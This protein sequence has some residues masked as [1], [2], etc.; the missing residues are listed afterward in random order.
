MQ[1]VH[2]KTS[3]DN[4]D[5]DRLDGPVFEAF[6]EYATRIKRHGAVALLELCNSGGA[7]EEYTQQRMDA[8]CDTFRRGAVFARRAGF[9]GVLIHGGHGFLLQQ[10]I[11]PLTNRRNDDYG[12]SM[13]NRARFPI[14]ILKALRDG[15]GEDGILEMRF[16]AQDGVEGGM[17]IEDSCAFFR[18]I[19]GIPDI[20]HVSNGLKN[21][22][23]R[24][25][26]FTDMYDA[27]GHNIQYA[28][29][30]KAVV[31]KSK[32]AVIGGI[33][34]PQMCEDA[35]AAGKT[36]FVI[37]SRQAI[38][39]P[40]FPNKAREGRADQ[41]RR[42]I[43]CF[44]CYPGPSEHETEA[45]WPPPGGLPAP[46]GPPPFGQFSFF[47]CPN[48]LESMLDAI[49]SDGLDIGECTINPTANLR[50]YPELFPEV[51]ESRSVLVIGGSLGGMEAAITAAERGHRV[52]LV[53]SRDR[54]GGVLNI[55]EH[56]TGKAG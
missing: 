49:A 24:T 16:S 44:N 26:T 35:I 1:K 27:H 11:S 7:V 29:Q 40:E 23:N 50:V 31:R 54:L 6:G 5:I 51:K 41:I 2:G 43:R 36:D 19:D 55:M 33:N 56:D 37:L 17:T 30:V 14:R 10:F 4:I 21:K 32:V 53:E 39:D 12:G 22:G 13:E 47:E 3:G 45:Q 42:C 18:L 46:S 8:V 28:A 9:D 48:P 38:A 52:T 25:Y 34:D 15:L 20:I